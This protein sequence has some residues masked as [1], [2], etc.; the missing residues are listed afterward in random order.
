[1][2][3]HFAPN[4]RMSPRTNSFLLDRQMRDYAQVGMD[5]F[6]QRQVTFFAALLLAAYYYSLTLA[7]VFVVLIAIS[8]IYDYLVFKAIL[9]RRGRDSAEA[10]KYL[11]MLYFGA[12]LSSSII[13][14]YAIGI[15][16]V[17]DAA[18][19]FVPL[20]FLFA[21]ALFAGM[22]NHHLVPVLVIRLSIYG[23]AFLFIPIRAIVLTGA[24]I[25]SELWAQ[26]FT[27]I[28]VLY[29]IID[30][31]RIFLNFYRSKLE[32]FELLKEEARKSRMAYEAKAEFLSTMSHELRTPLTSIK[33][34]VE[35][36]KSGSIGALPAKVENVLGIAQRNCVRLVGLVEDVLDLQRIETGRMTLNFELFDIVQ[37]T[38]DAIE[39]NRA[40]AEERGV[41]IVFDQP[42]FQA[43]V[44][45]D[46]L[47]LEQVFT[48][49]LSNACKFS[50]RGGTVE[51]SIERS[52]HGVRVLFSDQGIGLAE[53]ER[54][55]VFDKFSQVDA[56]DNRP[57]GGTGLGMNIAMRIM[58]AFDGSVSYRPN[59]DVGTT[60]FIDLPVAENRSK[61]Q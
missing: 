20:F 40:Y 52:E 55:R 60:F 5:L 17:Q 42:G 12:V 24:D 8:E 59:K 44:S 9:R 6:V 18:M 47:R 28:F 26:L 25:R 4:L 11:Y 51:V 15:A 1:M 50:P 43:I 54:E 21:A 48:N 37:A 39:V 49:I 57:I 22:N 14:F 38:K 61:G 45:A 53:C 23:A 56:G 46:K 36:V 35:L 33:G 27:S 31:S 7:A 10:R 19:H 58:S 13:A 29:F 41:D 2:T 32:Q 34:A 3:M 16:Y 30:C